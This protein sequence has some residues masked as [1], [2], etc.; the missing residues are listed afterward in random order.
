MNLNMITVKPVETTADDLQAQLF[1]VLT[2]PAR[3]AILQILRDGEHCV[4]H[5]EAHLGYRQAYI[6][7]QLAVLRDA[8][9]ISDRRDGWNIFY[10]VVD[11]RIYDVLDAASRMTGRTAAL[12]TEKNDVTCPCPHCSGQAG[13]EKPQDN[14]R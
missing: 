7:Q 11:A 3:L 12:E 9:L 1:K 8:G 13:P 2:H 6:S 4:C 10:R 5:M 14:R